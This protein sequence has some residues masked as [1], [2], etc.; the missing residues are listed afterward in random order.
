MLSAALTCADSV[1]HACSGRKKI[2]HEVRML[3]CKVRHDAAADRIRRC[4]GQWRLSAAEDGCGPL[5]KT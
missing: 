3:V 1:R 2:W 5:I 4:M